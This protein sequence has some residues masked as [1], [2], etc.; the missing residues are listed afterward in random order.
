LDK[1]GYD[2]PYSVEILSDELRQMPLDQA[3]RRSYATASAMW[4]VV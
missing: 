1:A 2:G 3:A 4:P